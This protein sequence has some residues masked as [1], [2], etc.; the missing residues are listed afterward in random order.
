MSEN[1]QRMLNKEEE[2]YLQRLEALPGLK[3]EVIRLARADLEYGLPLE[4][5]QS[6]VDK[7]RDIKCMKL[8]SKCL[9]SGYGMDMTRVLLAEEPDLSR[10]EL[11]VEFYGRGISLDGIQKA[12]EETENAREMEMLLQE[13]FRKKEELAR[14]EG[15]VPLYAQQLL[16]Q[17]QEIVGQIHLQ[18]N[19]YGKLQRAIS[20]LEA[21]KKE[22]AEKERLL[23]EIQNRDL[24]ICSQQDELDI[25]YKK[26]AQQRTEIEKLVKEVEYLRSTVA[27]LEAK[28]TEKEETMEAMN[29]SVTGSAGVPVYYSV[30]VMDRGKVA[31]RVQMEHTGRKGN[32]PKGFWAKLFGTLMPGQ[33]IVKKVIAAG[34]DEQQLARVRIAME[35]G[36]TDIQMNRIINPALSPQKMSEIIDLAVLVNQNQ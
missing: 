15:E 16:T 17:I 24:Q 30:P 25:G 36:L 5:V 22:E 12:M 7:N 3:V 9:R 2:D 26:L 18:E 1:R 21:S 8:Y 4:Q 13:V 27:G 19:M 20:I 32:A 34:L 6:Y 28:L 29:G 31:G 33:D 23:Q 14:M 35:K 10:C 11:A